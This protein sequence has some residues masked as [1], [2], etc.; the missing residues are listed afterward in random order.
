M[1]VVLPVSDPNLSL[2]A[3]LGYALFAFIF[4][5]A[6]TPTFVRFLRHNHLGKQLRVTAVDGSDAQVFRTYHANKRGTP[7]MGGLLIWGSILF[8]IL[9]SRMLS[10]LGI[11]EFSLLHRGQVYLPLFTLVSMGMLGALDDYFNI[12]GWGKKHG[13]DVLPKILSILLI[14][15]VGAY[16][17]S[18]RL[19]YDQIH[20][21]FWGDITLGWW[22]VPLFIFIIVGTSNAVNITDGLDGLAGGLLVLAFGA[23]SVVAYL[24]GWT[25]LAAFCAVCVGAIA[26][27]LWHNVPPAMFFMGDTGAL[28]L[29]GVLGVIALMTDTVLV[30]PFVGAVFVF[31]TFSVIIQLFS[32]RFFKR[33]VFRA[34][35]LH[36]HLEALDWGESKVTMRLWIIGAFCSF[37]G[38]IIGIAG[39]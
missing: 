12:M 39:Q 37:L 21:P 29:G 7:T 14:S 20:I 16:W 6:L 28:A 3:I 1:P 34:A 4:G 23:F 38:I 24:S 22:Y 31:E 35:P 27:F 13:L 10:F 18:A 36:H 2:L 5:L 26:A 9:F 11:V 17:F 19:G 32:K 33:K 8:T 30:L 15:C 25:V